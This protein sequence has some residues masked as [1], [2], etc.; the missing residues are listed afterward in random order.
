MKKLRR[1]QK[2]FIGLFTIPTLVLFSI[3]V[4]WPALNALRYSLFEWSGFTANMS[5]TGLK[6]YTTAFRDNLFYSS[7][8]HDIYMILFKE[9]MIISF[10]LFFAII[11]SYGRITRFEKKAYQV[12]FFFP[13]SISVIIIATVW[14]LILHPR[15]GLLNGLLTLIGRDDL[16]R[17]WL[18]TYDT[19]MPSLSFI[20]GWAGIGFYMLV[21][22]AGLASISRDI[23]DS[24]KLEGAGFFTKLFFIVIPM[25]R[26]QLKFALITIL[27][28]SF[29]FN[30]AIVMALTRGGPNNQSHVLSSYVY[31]LSFI[32][33]RTGYASSIAVMLLLI[34]L[35]CTLIMSRLPAKDWNG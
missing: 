10:A 26:D 27:I 20:A 4:L 6:N 29:N 18:G 31:E 5:F 32:Q 1:D 2:I 28:T 13:D 22:L 23:T 35:S 25:L 19:V 12:V 9:I 3:F 21:F 15:I 34:S 16:T 17:A 30:Y 24:V 14:S 11:I 33:A 7:L 8:K